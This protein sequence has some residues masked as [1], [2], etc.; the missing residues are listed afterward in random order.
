MRRKQRVPWGTTALSSLT[1]LAALNGGQP[2]DKSAGYSQRL[3]RSR[4][5]KYSHVNTNKNTVVR[6][7]KRTAAFLKPTARNIICTAR[8]II[9]TAQKIICTAGKILCAA[10]KIMYTAGKIICAAQ[11]IICA[12]QLIMCT[13]RLFNPN[14][15]WLKIQRLSL[16]KT[17]KKRKSCECF[18][19]ISYISWFS[20]SN[21]SYFSITGRLV[22]SG[23]I[24]SIFT[25]LL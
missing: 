22:F 13:A 5:I 19:N 15:R 1:G 18:E 4:F 11:K 3:R 9:C 16:R 25:I 12:A 17:R 21:K 20:R 8:N 10:Q 24:S 23:R 7:P 2:C 6:F 14:C